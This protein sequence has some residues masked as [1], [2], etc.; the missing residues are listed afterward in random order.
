MT[1]E[2]FY[3]I[4]KDASGNAI[5]ETSGGMVYTTTPGSMNVPAWF[6]SNRQ[7]SAPAE[8]TFALQPLNPTQATQVQIILYLPLSDFEVLPDPC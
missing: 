3:A 7:V 1:S 4:F 8:I 2:S 6:S 5:A